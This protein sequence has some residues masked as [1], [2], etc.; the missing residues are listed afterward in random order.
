MVTLC[1]HCYPHCD[2][3]VYA[4]YRY[5][6]LNKER[7]HVTVDGCKLHSEEHYQ[8]LARNLEYCQDFHCYKVNKEQK[9]EH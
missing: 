1:K 8:S 5:L 7:I 2:F 3:C 6:E 9:E 4:E